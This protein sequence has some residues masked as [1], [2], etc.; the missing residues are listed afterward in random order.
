MGAM[1]TSPRPSLCQV[2]SQVGAGQEGRAEGERG[3][4]ATVRLG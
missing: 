2:G 3:L 1:A 4:Q